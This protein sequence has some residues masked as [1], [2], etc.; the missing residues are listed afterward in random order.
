MK[1]LIIL[2]IKHPPPKK[3][4]KKKKKKKI[5]ILDLKILEDYLYKSH[6][7]LNKVMLLIIHM[8]DRLNRHV[9]DCRN[10]V[11]NQFGGKLC[12]L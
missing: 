8:N 9:V 6:D 3:K 1:V 10:F 2:L 11:L 5:C 12:H 7:S 4:K